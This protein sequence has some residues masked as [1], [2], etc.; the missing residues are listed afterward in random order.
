M[1]KQDEKKTPTFPIYLDKE[2]DSI[3]HIKWLG[4]QSTALQEL[5]NQLLR[6]IQ[7]LQAELVSKNRKWWERMTNKYNLDPKKGYQLE[8][9]R[10][11]MPCIIEIEKPKEESA[12]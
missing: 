8:G 5:H 9:E 12:A 10:S 11:P 2:D 3:E 1:T 7:P 4:D 6:Y